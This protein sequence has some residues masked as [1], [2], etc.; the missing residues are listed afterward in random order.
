MAESHNF[1]LIPAGGVSPVVHKANRHWSGRTAAYDGPPSSLSRFPTPTTYFPSFFFF[2][3]PI[4]LK[5]LK[6]L[7]RPWPTDKMSCWAV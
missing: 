3:G 2:A 5:R 7:G 1:R 4:Q 6:P